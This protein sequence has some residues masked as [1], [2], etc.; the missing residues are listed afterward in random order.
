MIRRS[1]VAVIAAIALFVTLALSAFAWSDSLE[2]QPGLTVENPVGYNL[3][4]SDSGLHL[5]THGPGDEHYFTARLHTDGVFEDVD[6]VRLENRDN[7]E[8]TDGGHTIL[9]RFHTYNFTDG[10]N[11]R[12]NGG[13]ALHLKLDLDGK[14][15]ATDSIYLGVNGVHPKTNPFTIR[16]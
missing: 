7:F 12:I 14:R 10:L 8:V 11:F 6:A 5:R 16:R 15:I 4:H 2:G 1:L 3:W 9:L 13:R